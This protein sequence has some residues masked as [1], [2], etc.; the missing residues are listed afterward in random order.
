MTDHIYTSAEILALDDLYDIQEKVSSFG[1]PIQY[2]MTEGELGWLDFVTTRYS[3]ADWIGAHLDGDILT[4]DDTFSAALDD[5]CRLAGK[6][7]CL[8]DDTALQKLFFWCYSET[9]DDE[10]E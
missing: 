5:D 1:L 3:I 7:V 6:A 10:E 2:Q 8:S 9:P 4:L